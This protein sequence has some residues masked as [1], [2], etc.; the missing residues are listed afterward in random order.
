LTM[1]VSGNVSANTCKHTADFYFFALSLTSK[2]YAIGA[3]FPTV[4]TDGA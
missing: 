3:R 1:Q 2:I 4:E